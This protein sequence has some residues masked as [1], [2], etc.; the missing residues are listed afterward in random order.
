MIV[1]LSSC[2]GKRSPLKYVDKTLVDQEALIAL[3]EAPISFKTLQTRILKPKCMKCHSSS[4]GRV[5]PDL[6]PIDFDSY[7]SMM[8]DRFIP[9]LKKGFPEKSRLYDVV[10]TG[11]M[12]IRER[13]NDDEIEF[14]AKWIRACAPNEAVT[15]IPDS[16]RSDSNP[17]DDDDFDSDTFD[18]NPILIH[19]DFDSEEF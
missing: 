3:S 15:A 5:E 19:D 9:L 2:Y 10:E 14:I 4:A 16:C 6:D 7:D 8:V 18:E 12:P 1:I 13:L 11:E 17:D